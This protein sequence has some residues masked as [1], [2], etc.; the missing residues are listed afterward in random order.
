MSEGPT[1]PR[2]RY[3]MVS[4]DTRA[5]AVETAVA[6]IEGGSTFTAACR[7]VAEQVGVSE[8]AVRHWVNASGRRPRG[9]WDEVVE[10]RAS[11]QAALRLNRQLSRGDSA[12]L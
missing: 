2:R 9:T 5:A 8:T 3:R 6:Q 11:L 4:A 7:H 10:L 1:A 12:D